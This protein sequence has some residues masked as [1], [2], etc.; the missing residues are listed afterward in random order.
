[1]RSS[2]FFFVKSPLARRGSVFAKRKVLKTFVTTIYERR[3]ACQL[4]ERGFSIVKVSKITSPLCRMTRINLRTALY[5]DKKELNDAER[6]RL[7]RDL[8]RLE[9][10]GIIFIEKIST[11][12]RSTSGDDII[13]LLN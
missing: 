2:S 9:S 6:K 5:P 4:F 11:N 7:S 3:G 10:E 8:Q 12:L 13:N 1:M